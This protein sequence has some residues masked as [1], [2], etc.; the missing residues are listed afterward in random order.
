MLFVIALGWLACG[1]GLQPAGGSETAFTNV[2]VS[3]INVTP[4][5]VDAILSGVLDDSADTVPQHV[6][7]SDTS[8]TSFV[9]LDQLVVGDPLDPT[10]PGIT[11]HTGTE[12]ETIAAFSMLQGE[13][14]ACGDVIEII[15]SGID[16]ASFA[17]DV[18]A[19]TPP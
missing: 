7:P 6:D 11:I 8:D 4:F 1:C 12:P 18:F 15:V 5:G 14:F 16:A 17:V 9:C 13:S 2:L 10:A 19:L 3:V